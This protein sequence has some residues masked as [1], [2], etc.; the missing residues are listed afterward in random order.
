VDEAVLLGDLDAEQRTAVTTP[1]TL[2]AVIAAAG[3]GKTRVLARR[4][5]YR[6]A[7]G[8]AEARHTLALTFTRQAA[9]ELRRR[10]RASG[11]REWI[12]AGTFHSVALAVLRQRWADENRP[13]PHVTNDR[14][15]L[16]AGIAAGCPVDTIVAE[17]SW[18]AARGIEPAAYV[19]AARAVNRRCNVPPA[20]VAQVLSDYELLKRR[21]GVVDIDDLLLLLGRELEGDPAFADAVRWRFRH[22]L[23]DEAQDLNPVQYG[24][25]RL[26]VARRNDLFLVG[27]P[28]QAIYGFNGSDPS[29]LVEVERHLP[30]VEI[31]RLTTNRRCTPQIVAAGMHVLAV[32]DQH[33]DAVSARDDGPAVEILAAG[34]E[35]AEAD[36]VARLVARFPPIL[37]RDGQVA[38]LARTHDQLGTLRSALVAAGVA[39]QQQAVPAGSPLAAAL[40][41]ATALRSAARLR[42]WSHDVLETA[43][44]AVGAAM[45]AHEQA[46]RRVAAAAL[47]FLR[48]QPAG[49]GNGFRSWIFTTAALAEPGGDAGVELLTFHAAKGREWHTVVVAGVETGLVPHRSATTLVTR[50]EEA[51]LLHVA[52]TRA[53]DRLIVTSAERRRGYARKPSPFIV[54]LPTGAVAV[55]A[56]PP[57]LAHPPDLV[58]LRIESLH[59]WRRT[60]ARAAALLP[61]QICSDADISA[62]AAAPPS[63]PDELSAL[64][65]F[66]PVTA[67]QAFEPISAALA[68]AD[69]SP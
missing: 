45:S 65:G 51:R 48:E 66:G 68:A 26:V 55:V 8:S 52:M 38:V 25:L 34:D 20:T 61:A 3:S 64:T 39:V 56:R 42:A 4:I 1:S 9:G 46:D 28:A 58:A 14:H 2:V 11:V 67:A 19:A 12:E 53:A 7:T 57:H 59:A 27:D 69:Q 17:R 37:R 60:A 16:I 47:D 21:R 44:P 23:V 35:R 13:S 54:G 22:V 31:V 36:L 50:A 33:G 29:L 43:P 49:D 18:C 5:A 15:R 40:S 6:V 41:T 10:L 30:G 24:L 63:S 32:S 62:I